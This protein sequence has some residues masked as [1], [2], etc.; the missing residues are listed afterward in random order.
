MNQDDFQYYLHNLSALKSLHIV[1]P[2]TV[3]MSV[4]L[5]RMLDL[6]KHSNETLKQIGVQNR[7]RSVGRDVVRWEFY[8]YEE[9]AMDPTAPWYIRDGI[10]VSLKQWDEPLGVWPEALLVVR[11]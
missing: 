9:A 7:V 1:S 8:R 10:I 4:S 5:E 3:A 2:S 11:T 6:V